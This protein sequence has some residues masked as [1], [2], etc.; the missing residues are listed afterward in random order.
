MCQNFSNTMDYNSIWWNQS[1][2]NP[3]QDVEGKTSLTFTKN[4]SEKGNGGNTLAFA[5][6]FNE[7]A[8]AAIQEM[9][10][11]GRVPMGVVLMNFAGEAVINLGGKDYQ[12]Q[13]I[14]M[15]GLVMSNNFLFDLPEVTSNTK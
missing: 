5:E 6:K 8:T 13:G 2:P 14:R 1:R 10:N 4:E 12:V 9:I 3:S 7:L 11:T 15:P